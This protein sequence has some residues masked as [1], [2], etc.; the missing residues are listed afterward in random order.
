MR[1]DYKIKGSTASLNVEVEKD[2]VEKLKAM[3]KQTGI[4]LAELANTAI[5]RFCTHHS[6]F[7]PPEMLTKRS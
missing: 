2:L 7:L 3:E 5:K 1:D 6:D 4:K